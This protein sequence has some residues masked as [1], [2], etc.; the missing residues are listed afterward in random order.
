MHRRLVV[1]ACVL[2][3]AGET[4]HPTSQSCGRVLMEIFDCRHRA[5][6]TP[7]IQT[8]WDAHPSRFAVAWR[9]RMAGRRLFV[10]LPDV[11]DQELRKRIET[12]LDAEQHR[13][14]A[15]KDVHLLE[16]AQQ[17]DRAIFS[18]DRRARALFDSVRS[19][20]PLLSKIAWVDPVTHCESAVSW[21]RAG[22]RWQ[23]WAAEE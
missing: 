18:H 16:A 13:A 4:E 11:A 22:A 17:T 7:A 5:V 9:T 21:L 8:E 20:P 23:R 15:L 2:K 1:D 10:S 6:V 14:D 19:T 3:A 12:G